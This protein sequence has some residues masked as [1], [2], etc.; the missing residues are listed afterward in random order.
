MDEQ[1]LEQES[2]IDGVGDVNETVILALKEDIKALGA[3]LARARIVASKG[4]Y[5]F[6]DGVCAAGGGK[7]TND[8]TKEYYARQF[9]EAIANAGDDAAFADILDTLIKDE[10]GQYKSGLFVTSERPYIADLP[11][12]SDVDR[13]VVTK[14]DFKKMGYRERVRLKALEPE[15]YAELCD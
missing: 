15:M 14:E 4:V 11:A 9:E 8:V 3:E 12:A 10:S 2:V 1:A 6:M 5:A 13:K 7:W